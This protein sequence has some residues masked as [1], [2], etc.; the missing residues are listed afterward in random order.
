MKIKVDCRF[1]KGDRPCHFHK[2]EGVHC[3][4]C[5]YYQKMAK[6]ILFIKLGAIGDVIRTTPLLLKLKEQYPDAEITWVTYTPEVIPSIVDN[7]LNFDLKNIL[8]LKSTHFDLLYNLDKDLEACALANQLSADV[9]KGFRLEMGRCVPI[10]EDSEAKW[11]TGLFDD[12][13]RASQK[14]YPQ[15]IFE[16][17]G[18]Q[19]NGERYI[20]DVTEEKWDIP[21]NHPLI[22]L[23]TGCG[24]RWS[25][26]LWP[27]EN[28]IE[29]TQTLKKE[30]FGV[31]LLGGESEDEKN[32]IIAKESGATYVGHFPLK[33]FFTLMDQCD[34]IVTAVSMALHIAIALEKKVVLFNNIFNRNE[35][36]LY[37]LGEIIEPDV[38]CMGC[39]KRECPKKC[40]D[41]I[42]PAQVFKACQRVLNK[43]LA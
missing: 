39:F 13:N 29:L 6:R 16:I 11:L 2:E 22:G 32:R 4:D 31:L 10:D 5:S 33:R 21:E 42:K 27:I 15:E 41:L 23:N 20:L 24:E 3:E 35:F 17:C 9:K 12:V 25:T 19:F 38:E 43:S 34:L 26:R 36:E 18:L 1:F 7:A 28:W 8:L 37:G 30:G 40:M 14:S